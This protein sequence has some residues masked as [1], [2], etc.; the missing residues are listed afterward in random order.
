MAVENES[1]T[2][3]GTLRKARGSGAGAPPARPN[4]TQRYTNTRRA[5]K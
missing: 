5:Q 2:R 3:G 4:T 1:E